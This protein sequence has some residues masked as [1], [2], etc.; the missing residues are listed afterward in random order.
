MSYEPLIQ[1]C[2][3]RPDFALLQRAYEDYRQDS[4][5]CKSGVT[6]QC[7]VRM[8]VA[9]G[10]SGIDLLGFRNQRRVHRG[11]ASCQLAIDHVLGARELADHLRTILPAPI[12]FTGPARAG[13]R[14]T[15]ALRKGIVYFDNCFT[16]V[17]GGPQTGDHIDLW[18]GSGYYNEYLRVGAGGNSR[19]STDLFRR[20]EAVWFF[21]LAA[22]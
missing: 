12:R 19:A 16:R 15:L 5:P 3:E 10:R 7:A 9:L 11:R 22:A 4:A 17:P 14:A 6:N 8:S 2:V 20:A 21:Q 1:I 13:A 18:D